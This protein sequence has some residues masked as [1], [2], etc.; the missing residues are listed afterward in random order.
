MQSAA[1]YI[2]QRKGDVS[3][4]VALRPV[5]KYTQVRGVTGGVPWWHQEAP[6]VSIRA[7]FEEE[8]LRE[9]R[10]KRDRR[11]NQKGA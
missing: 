4:W 11:D 5:L 3:Q 6:E 2:G 1:M 8:I 7:T 10:E 9:A